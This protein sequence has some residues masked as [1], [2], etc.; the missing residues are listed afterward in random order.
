MQDAGQQMQGL[1]SD[2][3]TVRRLRGEPQACMQTLALIIALNTSNQPPAL[4]Q[5]APQENIA[6]GTKDALRFECNSSC[7]GFGELCATV[8]KHTWLQHVPACSAKAVASNNA[9]DS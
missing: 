9:L 5:A 8:Q 4:Q 1:L 7:C 3:N 2:E 6:A